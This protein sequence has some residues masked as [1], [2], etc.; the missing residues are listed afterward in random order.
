MNR[1]RGSVLLA[2]VCAGLAAMI[3][4]GLQ[5]GEKKLKIAVIPKGTTHVFWKSVERGAKRA[6]EDL[7]ADI[8]WKGPLKENDR[9]QQIALVQQFTSQ[10]GISGIVLAETLRKRKEEDHIPIIAVTALA[11]PGDEAKI[12]A[13]GTRM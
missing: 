1:R 12:F 2:C 9:S 10:G 4:S 7:N 5:P 6:G 13:S 8:V 3:G 11:M